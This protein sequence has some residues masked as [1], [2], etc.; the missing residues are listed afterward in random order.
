VLP[1]FVVVVNHSFFGES[2]A[3]KTTSL[4]EPTFNAFQQRER[5]MTAETVGYK[6]PPTATRFKPGESGNPSGRP[7]KKKTLRDE[8]IEELSS[9]I[10]VR[11]GARQIEITK[12]QAIMK[13]LV[14]SGID[15]NLRGIKILLSFSDQITGG[16]D[17]E[18][19][20]QTPDDL[21]LLESFVDRQI[22]RRNAI[23]NTNSQTKDQHND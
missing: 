3:S 17:Q 1:Q 21:E 6:R 20:E 7:K 9:T 19:I 5:I 16:N 22:R 10:Q 12:G 11:E 15:S 2:Y 14:K 23:S 13:A 8:L 4:P 18:P